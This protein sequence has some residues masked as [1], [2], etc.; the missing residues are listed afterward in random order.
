VAQIKANAYDSL[1]VAA[2]SAFS[3]YENSLSIRDRQ[4]LNCKQQKEV[5]SS[6]VKLHE[7][8]VIYYREQIRLRDDDIKRLERKQRFLKIGCVSLGAVA[9]AGIIYGLIK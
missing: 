4:I 7:D 5:L 3:A 9:G 2:D 6:K 1:F 8:G